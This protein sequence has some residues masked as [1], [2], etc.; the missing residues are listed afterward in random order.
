VEYLVTAGRL[1]VEPDESSSTAAFK[2]LA[3][4]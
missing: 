2:A 3:S 4:A 1:D